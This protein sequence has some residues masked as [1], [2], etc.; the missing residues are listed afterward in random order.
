MVVRVRRPVLRALTAGLALAASCNIGQ[1]A[2]AAVLDGCLHS[3]S[4][5]DL[6]GDG[7]DD[8]VVGNPYATVDGQLE[9]GQ[10]TVLFG[11]AD[12]RI[13]EGTRRTLTQRDFGEIPEAGDHFGW[14]L[15][16]GR[17]DQLGSCAAMLDGAPGED[18]G[19]AQDAGTA[20]LGTCTT[21]YVVLRT[22][23]GATTFT[24]AGAF[25]LVEADDER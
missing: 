22:H 11:D 9:A 2:S 1:S 25:G 16:V 13:A 10:V 8:A 3:R 6:D 12:G 19:A 4:S 23:V 15:A 14:S 24:Q 21:Y 20:H 7:F 18:R 5:I 17:S